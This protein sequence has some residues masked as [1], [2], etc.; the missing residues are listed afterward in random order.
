MY[1]Y[2]CTKGSRKCIVLYLIFSAFFVYFLLFMDMKCENE[3]MPSARQLEGNAEGRS[4][5]RRC[6]IVE[7]RIRS[8][9]MAR[10]APS[11]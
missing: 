1:I 4:V 8:G 10:V 7:C 5:L 2:V 3:A 11:C 9:G 6:S